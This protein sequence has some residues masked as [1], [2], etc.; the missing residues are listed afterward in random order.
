MVL[1]RIME[2]GDSK[3]VLW[4]RKNFSEDEMKVVLLSTRDMSPR[5]ANYW[6]LLLDVEREKVKC[7]KEPFRKAQKAL[8][9][10]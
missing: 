8:W 7:M 3:A 9:P 2:H 4:M 1:K 10:Y 6:A 5:S